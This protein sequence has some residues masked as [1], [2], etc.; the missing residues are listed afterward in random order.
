[1]SDWS[2]KRFVSQDSDDSHVPWLCPLH[3]LGLTSIHNSHLKRLAHMYT[4]SLHAICGKQC[5]LCFR[6]A[7]CVVCTPQNPC[8]MKVEQDHVMRS[9]DVEEELVLLG[10][11]LVFITCALKQFVLLHF[12]SSGLPLCPHLIS[13]AWLLGSCSDTAAGVTWLPPE[14]LF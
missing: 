2:L 11:Q 1:M 3:P 12:R 13:V 7:S 8:E 9:D 4:A 10:M 5:C 14:K 6:D